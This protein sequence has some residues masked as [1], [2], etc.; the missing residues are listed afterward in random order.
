MLDQ[1]LKLILDVAFGLV[2][3]ALLLRFVMQAMRAPFRNPLGSAVM[4]LTD[5][6]VKPMRKLIPGLGG[7]DWASLLAAWLF[8]ALWIFA[9][10]LLF[11]SGFAGVTLNATLYVL[12]AALVELLKAAIWLL[13]IV[14]FVQAILSWVAPDG[15]L[16]GLLNALTFP[17]LRPLRRWIPPLGGTLDLTP[18]LVIVLAQLALI[19][20]V[21][22]LERAVFALF[23]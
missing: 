20:P 8:Q 22:W 7:Y 13:I 1:A 4:A 12:A 23:R 2:V 3:Y 19:V 9:L 16:S 14:V 21:Q 11:G 18:L 17:F 5:W 15:P 6:I 10:F